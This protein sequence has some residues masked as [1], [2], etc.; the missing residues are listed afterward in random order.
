MRRTGD[1]VDA[2]WAVAPYFQRLA[3][4]NF[5]RMTWYGQ[6]FDR[7]LPAAR[8]CVSSFFPLY[9]TSPKFR[10]ESCTCFAAS[11]STLVCA[12]IPRSPTPV[13]CSNE[14][15]G[16]LG[17]KMMIVAE[18]DVGLPMERGTWCAGGHGHCQPNKLGALR[19]ENGGKGGLNG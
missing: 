17:V 7:F 11:T 2:F 1:G 8:V 12:N 3:F 4:L 14:V 15:H 9:H 19:R 18:C 5:S 10:G 6:G 13:E 16:K